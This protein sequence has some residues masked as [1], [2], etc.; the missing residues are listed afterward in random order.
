[1]GPLDASVVFLWYDGEEWGLYGSVAFSQ[2]TPVAKECLGL[3]ASAEGTVPVSQPYDMPGLNHPAK[4]MGVQY[5][6]PATV[7]EYAVLNLR[8]A[9]IHDDVEWTCWSYG[10]YEDLKERPDFQQ[11]RRQH[12]NYQFLMREGAYDVLS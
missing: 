9:P 5:G 4:N 12:A 7:D 1:M 8:T 3:K 6:A 10:C 2:D 11:V